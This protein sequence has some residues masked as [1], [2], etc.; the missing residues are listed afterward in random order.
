MPVDLSQ[1]LNE[2]VLRRLAEDLVYRRGLDYFSHGHVESLE[3]A[4]NQVRA[5]VRGERSYQVALT[6]D[7]GVLDYTCGC[8]EGRTGIFCK[9]CVAAGLAWLN[10]TASSKSAKRSKTK[11][12]S[13][14][15]AAKV[16][17]AEDKEVLLRMLVEWAKEYPQLRDR[18]ILFAARRS[19]P[20]SEAAAVQL[21]FENAV[22]VGHRHLGRREA[23]A[24]ARGVDKAI[25]AI[26][27]L[28]KDGHPSAVIEV[29]ESGLQEL[30]GAIARVDD[31]NGH[32]ADLRDRLQDLH[33]QA[34]T[35]A[36]PEPVGLGKRLF[37]LELNS[38]LDV[39]WEAEIRYQKV[40]GA[41]GLQAYRELAEAEWKKVPER[42]G[43]R[44]S[45]EWGEHFR[46][47]HI[48]ESLA[49]AS[50]DVEQ[51]VAVMSR[52]LSSAFNYWQ[53][54]EVY[55]AAN[56]H[57]KA[58]VWV[59][60]GVMAFPTNTDLRLRKFAAEE[61][62]R[63]GRHGDAVQLMWV[64]FLERPFVEQYARLESHAKAA[65]V[66]PEWRE[67]ALAEIRQ[68]VTSANE[69]LRQLV[70]SRWNQLDMDNSAMVE[71]FLYE[72][73][74]EEAWCEAQAGGCSDLLW[75]S[76]AAARE[77]EHPEDA[78]PIYQKQAEAALARSDYEATVELLVKTA[79]LMQKINRGAEFRSRLEALR[80][81]YKAKR[82]FI[83]LVEQNRSRLC[84]G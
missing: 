12:V 24:W 34:C 50:G 41:K 52:D 26:E 78:A 64:S 62:V 31:S 46:I 81:Q 38:D 71:I 8:S 39:F 74:P 69:R 61:Y 5:I 80:A 75:L 47:T 25:D 35:E 43:R 84:L 21:A 57:D 40:L 27:Q 4:G 29:C 53:I 16:L 23:G 19:G 13:L 70:G 82:N 2:A 32:F 20:E 49:R 56:E 3:V 65:N 17:Q 10:R 15:D 51:L 66:W 30:L 22:R 44:E 7:D 60:K 58:L 73:N 45:S 48:M 33:Y 55:R 54:A 63:R 11:T 9:H 18:L 28:L 37:H 42:T 36:W 72:K 77:N 59:E 6:S 68:R 76:L 1:A 14:A 83:K 79:A 67:R